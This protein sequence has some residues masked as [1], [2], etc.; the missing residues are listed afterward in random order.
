[1]QD[2]LCSILPAF[3]N[4]A[5][6]RIRFMPKYTPLRL[7]LLNGRDIRAIC[8]IIQKRC[9][10]RLAQASDWFGVVR[11]GFGVLGSHPCV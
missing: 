2:A 6:L 7:E 8:N 1:M 5:Y 4:L 10:A 11:L 9:I 3:T